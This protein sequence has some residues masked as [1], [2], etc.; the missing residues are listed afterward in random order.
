M[1]VDELK[2]HLRVFRLGKRYNDLGTLI[3][4]RTLNLVEFLEMKKHSQSSLSKIPDVL[5]IVVITIFCPNM[6]NNLRHGH[7]GVG[8]AY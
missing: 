7:I 4:C 3:P 8:D 6:T 5:K 1:G 2:V